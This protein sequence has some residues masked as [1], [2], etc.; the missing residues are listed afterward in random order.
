[1]DD[2][3]KITASDGVEMRISS[4]NPEVTQEWVEENIRQAK[5]QHAEMKKKY[6][7][8]GDA[9]AAYKNGEITWTDKEVYIEV[10]L[11]WV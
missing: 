6:P 4:T 8:I 2:E 10:E 3:I 5:L 9:E 11:G 7:T 1:M